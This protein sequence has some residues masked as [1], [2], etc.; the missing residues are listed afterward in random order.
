VPKEF[1]YYHSDAAEVLKNPKGHIVIDDGRRFLK[2]TPLKFDVIATDPPPPIQAAGSSLLYSTEFYDVVKLH[3][4]PKGV[5]QIWLPGGDRMSDVAVVRSVYSSFPYVRSFPSVTFG[6]VHMLASMEPLEQYTPQQLL[7][8]MPASAQK[9]LTEWAQGM[10]PAAYFG[11]V[12][13]HEVPT[14]KLLNP[15]PEIRITDDQPFNEYFLLRRFR[16]NY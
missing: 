6:G 4:K 9:D 1:G 5:V 7:A 8:R 10:D 16:L 13:E 15:N 3:L 12:I 11:R 14:E 2:R